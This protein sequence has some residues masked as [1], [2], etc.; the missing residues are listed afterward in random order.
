[1]T[2]SR[3]VGMVVVLVA[4]VMLTTVA[5]A[6][7]ELKVNIGGYVKLDTAYQDQ[8]NTAGKFRVHPD[9]SSIVFDEG[10]GRDNVRARNDQFLIEA[11]QTRF[12]I[13]ATDEIG[14]TK[15][16]GFIQLDLFGGTDEDAN[17]VVSN[18]AV[19][20]LRHAYA[21]GTMPLGPGA[22]TLMAGQNWSTFMNTDVAVPDT[23]DFNGPA[24]QL[25]AR[26]PQIRL[27]Y[28]I[29]YG[30][31]TLNLIGA[32]QAEAVNFTETDQS[33][34]LSSDVSAARQEGQTVP[35]FV[36]KVQWLS[37]FLEAEA[38]GAISQAKG[39]APSGRR[40]TGTVWGV[41]GSAN[42]PIGPLKIHLHA[43]RISGMHGEANGDMPDAVFV[44]NDVEPVRSTGFYG[45][46]SYV[47]TPDTTLNAVYG[48]RDA[49]DDSDSGFGLG[50]TRETQQERQQSIHLNVLQK[51]WQ[52][53]QVGAEFQRFW[54]DAFGQSE[55]SNNIYRLALWYFF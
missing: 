38:A 13:T 44:L 36:G 45:G 34:A 48:L 24:G 6:S 46:V 30:K 15:L 47:L 26:Q 40:E 29:P 43:D 11:R 23:I 50:T 42:I 27:T 21:E 31:N 28:G 39:I 51:F 53:F 12:H 55:G 17:S 4:A 54:V 2:R 14:S 25:F 41:Q 35:R 22:F 33:V 7:A 52:R 49:D 19:P 3:A 10:P 37:S 8:M 16:K 18:S 20:R 9:P 32:V 5:P 1:M